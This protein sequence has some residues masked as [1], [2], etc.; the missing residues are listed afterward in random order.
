MRPVIFYV[1][2]ISYSDSFSELD[3]IKV[4]I[5]VVS[6]TVQTERMGIKTEGSN[7]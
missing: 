3:F 2:I 1:F 4:I 7:L 6:V 5:T